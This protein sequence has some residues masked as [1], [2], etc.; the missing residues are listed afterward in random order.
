MLLKIT[1]KIIPENASE[2]QGP[3]SVKSSIPTVIIII[4][5]IIIWSHRPFVKAKWC[6]TCLIGTLKIIMKA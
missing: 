3:G 6:T 5:I 2:Q 4:I 1:Q